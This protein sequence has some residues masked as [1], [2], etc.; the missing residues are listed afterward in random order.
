MQLPSVFFLSISFLLAAMWLYQI[1]LAV[2]KLST[3]AEGFFLQLA[4][5]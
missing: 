1:Q 2:V 5:L 3:A 4:K